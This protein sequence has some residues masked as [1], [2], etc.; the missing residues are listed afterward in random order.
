LNPTNVKKKKVMY[1]LE[2]EGSS[3][4]WRYANRWTLFKVRRKRKDKGAISITNRKKSKK[5]NEHE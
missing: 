1:S 3:F 4:L 2:N 5:K